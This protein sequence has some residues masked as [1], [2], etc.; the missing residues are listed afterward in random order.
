MSGGKSL[1]R[2]IEGILSPAATLSEVDDEARDDRKA[3]PCP[4]K[5]ET[6]VA[7]TAAKNAAIFMV[8][9]SVLKI[10]NGIFLW[11]VGGESFGWLVRSVCFPFLLRISIAGAIACNLNFLTAASNTSAVSG[12]HRV[13]SPP[14]HSI[15]SSYFSDH[16]KD[17]FCD[18]TLRAYVRFHFGG[19]TNRQGGKEKGFI[20]FMC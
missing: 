19:E 3:D 1:W 18:V 8:I 15:R 16:Q 4:P 12:Y 6:D 5:A 9:A 10:T 17:F 14:N 20:T 7:E 2:S 11:C 13:I